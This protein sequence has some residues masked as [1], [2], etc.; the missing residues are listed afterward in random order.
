MENENLEKNLKNTNTPKKAGKKT[1]IIIIILFAILSIF[2]YLYFF[3]IYKQEQNN[4]KPEIKDEEKENNKV[5]NNEDNEEDSDEKEDIPNNNEEDDIINDTNL[6]QQYKIEDLKAN[7]NIK[8]ND[9][10]NLIEEKDYISDIDTNKIKA[11]MQK[12]LFVNFFQSNYELTRFNKNILE[13]NYDVIIW[14]LIEN[15]PNEYH[16]FYG[17]LVGNSSLQG[18]KCIKYNIFESKYKKSYKLQNSLEQI[19]KNGSILFNVQTINNNKY[20]CY[21]PSYSFGPVI[22]DT[23]IENVYY[24]EETKKYSQIGFWLYQT[25]YSNNKN[26][27][28][29]TYEY[30][31]YKENENQLLT[32]VIFYKLGETS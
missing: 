9:Y 32:K 10:Q 15:I 24:N 12:A 18:A 22:I 16:L 25:P 6:P 2:G 7:G 30:E 3:R 8:N 1:L 19:I 28:Y 14:N 4:N 20:F 13:N 29:G 23:S 11:N 17:D 21:N 31:Y 27:N 26:T 5:E